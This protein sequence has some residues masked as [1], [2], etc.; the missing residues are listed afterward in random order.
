VPIAIC[1][2]HIVDAPTFITHLAVTHCI[3]Y[4]ATSDWLLVQR[5]IAVM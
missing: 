1:A 3:T 2:L 5:T 4:F